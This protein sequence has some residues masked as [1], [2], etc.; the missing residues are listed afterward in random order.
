MMISRT[1]RI[2]LSPWIAVKMAEQIQVF[3]TTLTPTVRGAISKVRRWFYASLYSKVKGD[4]REQSKNNWVKLARMLI[5]KTNEQ[6]VSDKAGRVVLYYY[7][8]DGV[9]VPVKAEIEYFEI[10]PLGKFEVTFS[11]S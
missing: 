2:Y 1:L 4:A 11:E 5:D 10:K 3:R 9:F 6:G 8:R 7:I